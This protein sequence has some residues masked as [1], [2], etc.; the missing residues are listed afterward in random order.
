MLLAETCGDETIRYEYDAQLRRTARILPDGKTTRYHYDAAGRLIGLDH[1]G[2]RVFFQRDALGRE[3][4][5]YL[6]RGEIDIGST[7]DVGGRLTDRWVTAPSRAGDTARAL[8]SQ[9]KWT[10][11]ALD[12]IR[13]MADLRWGTTRYDHDPIGRLTEAHRATRHE[14]LAYDA[15][16]SLEARSLGPEG[17]QGR[18]KIRQGNVLVRAD[19]YEYEYDDRRRRKKRIGVGARAGEVTEYFWDARDRLREVGLPDGGRVLFA[20]DAG[21][22]RVRKEV[23]P[24]PEAPGTVALEPSRVVRYLWDRNTLAAEI[25]SVR[26]ARVFV[27]DRRSFSPILQEE[28]G[29]V[30]A[31]VNDHQSTPKELVGE[32]GRVAWSAAHSAWGAV[33]E[34]WRDPKSQADASVDTPFRLLGQYADEETGLCYVRFRYFD[35]AVGRW[36]SSDPLGTDGG[37]NLFGWNG[38]PLLDPDPFGLVNEFDVGTMKTLDGGGYDRHELLNAG[39][40]R[41]NWKPPYDY[42]DGVVGRENP[43]IALTTNREPGQH[44]DIGRMQYNAG[45]SGQNS[46]ATF[47]KQTARQ[48]MHL[49]AEFLYKALR[50]HKMEPG[51]AKKKVEELYKKTLEFI[52]KNKLSC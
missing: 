6:Y 28:G 45:M 14:T 1:D 51:D 4:R 22:R 32:D 35:P 23:Y 18:W 37:P 11:D 15:A 50:A 16:S 2:R 5:R 44:Q 31:Y 34:S 52:K 43:A 48:N 17:I 3:V 10:Y 49:N 20:Y 27:V 9:R 19:E 47:A 40:M 41:T 38:S 30:F 21:G 46:S 25:D 42:R 13:T 33:V 12:R 26:G 36:L 7:Y 24:P 29:V 39:W 8:L